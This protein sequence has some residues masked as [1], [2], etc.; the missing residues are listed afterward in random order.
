MIRHVVVI[1]GT[2]EAADVQKREAGDALATL[3]PLTKG[4]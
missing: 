1:T 2:P 3:P 4:C